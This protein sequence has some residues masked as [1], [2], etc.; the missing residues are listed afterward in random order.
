MVDLRT[1]VPH[2][3]RVYDYLLG[4]KDNFAADRA[5]AEQGRRSNPASDV[6]PGANRDWLRRVVTFLTR[7]QGIGQFL[8]IGTGL[9]TSPNVHE[10]AQGVDPGARIVYI[11]HDPIVLAHAR[12]L[13]TSN[14]AGS[15]DYL[16]ADFRDPSRILAAAKETLDFDRP[17]ALLLVAIAHFVGDADEPHRIVGE[18]V[19]A[20]P[21][22]SFLAL[23]HLTGDFLPEQ[24]KKVEAIYAERGV[25]MQVRP[26]A[27][28]ERFFDGLDVIDPGLTLV[29]RWRPDEQD[30]F[31]DRSDELVSV[32]G[33]VARKP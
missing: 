26:K 10:V 15:T 16:D 6:A 11:D 20:L 3:A 17:V 4:G 25:T 5:A 31:A 1:E 2:P 21:S 18:L 23:S 27:E 22:G 9:P 12:A 28:I 24:W 8:D 19:D 14:P 32:Y 7:E 29:H 30:R 33:A 13:L